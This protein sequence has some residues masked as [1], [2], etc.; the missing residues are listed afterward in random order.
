[1][2]KMI[3]GDGQEYG[4]VTADQLR[5]W[6]ADN[7]ANGQTLIQAEGASDWRPLSTFPELSSGLPETPVPLE[8]AP[9]TA[10]AATPET[11]L[12]RDYELDIAH[13]LGRGWLLLSRHS[14][15]IPASTMVVWLITFLGELHWS[16]AILNII[17]AGALHGGLMFL[18]IRLIRG[19]PSTL[20]DVFAGFGGSFFNLMFVWIIT[21]FLSGVGMFFCVLPFIVFKVIWAFSL[22]IAADQGLGFW[23]SMEL[24]R[25]VVSKQFF[26]VLGL[27]AVAFL[28]VIVFFLYTTF[29]SANYLMETLGHSLQNFNPETFLATLTDLSKHMGPRQ[30]QMQLLVLLNMPFAYA[31]LLCAYEEIFGARRPQAN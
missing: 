27:L 30:L 8:S 29:E 17:I 22:P 9:E 20:L 15:L 31:S 4:P 6:V 7:R 14:I 13:C 5:E 21:H 18:M 26:R 19:Q 23:P 16:T 10:S 12:A 24:S 1:M 25:Q 3:G 11:V 2:F 28:P